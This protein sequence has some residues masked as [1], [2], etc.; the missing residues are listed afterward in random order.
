MST[1]SC[2]AWNIHVLLCLVWSRINPLAPPLNSNL[3][4]LGPVCLSCLVLLNLYFVLLAQRGKE[5][6]LNLFFTSELERFYN[7]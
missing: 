3:F 7:S 6:R 5:F 1:V 4:L 2:F